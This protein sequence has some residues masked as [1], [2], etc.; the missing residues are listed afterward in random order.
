LQLFF[1][2]YIWVYYIIQLPKCQSL[3]R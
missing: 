2:F 3:L 1:Y